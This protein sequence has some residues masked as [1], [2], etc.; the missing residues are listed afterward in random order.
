M[1]V[2]AFAI[3][4][5]GVLAIVSGGALAAAGTVETVTGVIT[6]TMCG[7][8]HTMMK[9]QPDADCV[10]MCV[11]GS[12]EYALYDGKNVWKLS[13]QKA[14]AK[15]AAKRVKVTGVA[16]QKTMTIKTASMEASE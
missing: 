10:R 14:A 15:F 12:A 4:F 5:G 8:K 9:G 3:V 16:D 13:D 6:D 11:R 7:A 2:T 1:K